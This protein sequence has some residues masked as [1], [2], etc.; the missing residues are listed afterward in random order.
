MSWHYGHQ[1]GLCNGVDGKVRRFS[2][3]NQKHVFAVLMALFVGM[4]CAMT[5][6]EIWKKYSLHCFIVVCV[7]MILVMIVGREINGANAGYH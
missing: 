5:P 1:F 4:L 2:V 6:T 7:L 3:P